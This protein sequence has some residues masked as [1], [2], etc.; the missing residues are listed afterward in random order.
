MI[1]V[2][3]WSHHARGGSIPYWASPLNH[4]HV[5][6]T[7]A[8]VI[9]PAIRS[10]VNRSKRLIWRA[11]LSHTAGSP[12]HSMALYR[13]KPPSTIYSAPV[14]FLRAAAKKLAR[15][16]LYTNG[17]HLFCY[18][19]YFLLSHLPPSYLSLSLSV[20]DH[21]S[22]AVCSI[23]GVPNG[24]Q[25]WIGCAAGHGQPC[26]TCWINIYTANLARGRY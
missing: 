3:E 21:S 17:Q 13:H 8:H 6:A 11:M 10:L 25:N 15:G 4:P 23:F 7:T 1:H 19:V 2:T 16:M 20:N 12:H 26:A 14:G 9:F 24:M 5:T 18:V 22:A